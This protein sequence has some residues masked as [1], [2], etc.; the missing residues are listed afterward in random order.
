MTAHDCAHQRAAVTRDQGSMFWSCAECG[1]SGELPIGVNKT[2]SEL[3][4][5][6][7]F[8]V[9]GY[10]FQA[11]SDERK[12]DT[13]HPTMGTLAPRCGAFVASTGEQCVLESDHD[14]AHRFASDRRTEMKI[15]NPKEWWL[16][17]VDREGDQLIGVGET[18]DIYGFQAALRRAFMQGAVTAI[19][20]TSLITELEAESK[21]LYPDATA[22]RPP[23]EGR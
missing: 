11:V 1:R 20:K 22:A 21:R 18:D 2:I 12:R 8:T 4:T 9:T 19:S 3:A 5:G 7:L 10:E 14:G 16:E 13:D 15:E 23:G 6:P 17:R